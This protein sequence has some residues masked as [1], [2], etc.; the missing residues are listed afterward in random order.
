MDELARRWLGGFEMGIRHRSKDLLPAVIARVAPEYLV[1]SCAL[2]GLLV[3]I[4][5]DGW[6][7]HLEHPIEGQPAKKCDVVLVERAGARRYHFEFKPLWPGGVA[8]CVGG[9]RK[10][11]IKLKGARGAYIVAFA[12]SLVDTPSEHSR[13]KRE[14]ALDELVRVASDTLGVQPCFG[15]DSEP[16]KIS[17]FGTEGLCRL[18]AWDADDG[19]ELTAE[20][21]GARSLREI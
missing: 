17:G 8:E 6:N 4:S 5:E 21:L 11:K 10:D 1:V 13:F 7:T 9:L 15:E 14:H 2:H 19:A 18:V 20:S 12:Y 3:E 16:I